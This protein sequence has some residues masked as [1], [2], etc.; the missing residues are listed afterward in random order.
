[1]YA[2]T[3]RAPAT[4]VAPTNQASRPRRSAGAYIQGDS[5]ASSDERPVEVVE[6]LRRAPVVGEEQEPEP[7]LGDEERLR[8]REQ[9]RDDPARLAPPVV[10]DGPDRSGAERRREHEECDGVVRR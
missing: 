2:L 4:R 8:E 9:V 1:M 3:P 6:P 7:D 5:A 10:G